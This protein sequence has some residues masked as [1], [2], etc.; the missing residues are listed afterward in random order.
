MIFKIGQ[1]VELITGKNMAADEGA[2]AVVKH[3]G[4]SYINVIW[5]RN[6][7]WK[8]QGDG[9]YYPTDFKILPVKHQQLLFSF[10]D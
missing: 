9:G 2:T 7:K 4:N 10:M 3:V 8:N 1:T 6:E 5:K